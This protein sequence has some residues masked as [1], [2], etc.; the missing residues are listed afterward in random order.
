MSQ[1]NRIFI[2]VT[3]GSSCASFCLGPIIAIAKAYKNAKNGD[4]IEVWADNPGFESDVKAWIQRTGNQLLELRKDPDKTVA[5]IK[6]TA[7]K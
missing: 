2:D 6:V 3:G 4:I 5:V 1:E 7:K